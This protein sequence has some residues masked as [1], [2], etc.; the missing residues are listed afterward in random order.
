MVF[1]NISASNYRTDKT[2]KDPWKNVETSSEKPNESPA[3][4]DLRLFHGCHYP[5]EQ[6]FTQADILN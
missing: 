6:G 5:E 2:D 1:K 3:T 4:S